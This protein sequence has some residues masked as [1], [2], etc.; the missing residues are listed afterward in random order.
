MDLYNCVYLK[1]LDILTDVL[2]NLLIVSSII[3]AAV[4]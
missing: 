3:T 1:N 4:K 2:G